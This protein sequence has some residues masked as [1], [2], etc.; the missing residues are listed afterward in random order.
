MPNSVSPV[1]ATH[2]SELFTLLRQA[3]EWH[4]DPRHT[5]YCIEDCDFYLSALVL[6]FFDLLFEFL[7]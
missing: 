6:Y 3:L 4:P 2:D 5:D 7:K 1:D